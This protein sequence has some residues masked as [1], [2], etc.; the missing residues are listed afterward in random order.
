[1]KKI[2]SQEP[3]AFKE[4]Q[5]CFK[6]LGYQ[7]DGPEEIQSVFHFGSIFNEDGWTIHFVVSYSP[8]VGCVE[9]MIL[10]VVEGRAKDEAKLHKIINYINNDLAVCHLVEYSIPGLATE[11]MIGVKAGLIITE[12]SLDKALFSSLVENIIYFACEYKPL[13]EKQLNSDTDPK[14]VMTEFV[15]SHPHL[16]YPGELKKTK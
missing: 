12:D 4:M 15:R 5:T 11:R 3:N 9:L 13:L 2:K 6:E 10:R 7:I 1:M 14:D 8:E 16:Y